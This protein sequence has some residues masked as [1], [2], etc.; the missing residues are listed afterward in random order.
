MDKLFFYGSLSDIELFQVDG[1]D[2]KLHGTGW[3]PHEHVGNLMG[4]VGNPLGQAGNPMGE[5]ETL[6]G[7]I[8]KIEDSDL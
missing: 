5:G 8:F 3:E 1:T 2:S 6:I 7:L 4:Q